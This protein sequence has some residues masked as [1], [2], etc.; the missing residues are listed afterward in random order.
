MKGWTVTTEATKSTTAREIYLHDNHHPNHQD[1]NTIIDI[2]GSKKSVATMAMTTELYR[3]NQQLKRKGG[4]PPTPAVEYALELPK[5]FRPTVKQWRLILGDVMTSVAEVCSVEIDALA[6]ITRAVLHKQDQTI[7]RNSKGR[8]IGSGDHC[9]VVVGKFTK[10][11]IYLRNLQRKT[12]TNAVKA[13]F[14]RSVLNRCGFDWQAYAHVE[15]LTIEAKNS[16]TIQLTK[17]PAINELFFSKLLDTV[18]TD[19]VH[20]HAS[21]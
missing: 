16:V 1:T 21:L 9:H 13:A 17:N 4:R 15:G 14:T 6:P 3:A 19:L 20:F 11:G 10:E 5:G 8:I 7:K 12:C 18:L 2:H